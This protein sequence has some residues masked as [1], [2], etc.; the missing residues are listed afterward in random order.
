MTLTVVTV[1]V[2]VTGTMSHNI[3]RHAECYQ[4][5]HLDC[6]G[7]ILILISMSV[8]DTYCSEISVLLYVCAIL[9]LV[10]A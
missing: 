6:C 7:A 4:G 2:Y 5:P 1:A 3:C 9:I 8:K 10:T